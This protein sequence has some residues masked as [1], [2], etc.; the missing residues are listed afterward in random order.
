MF[1]VNCTY[2]KV[3]INEK[4][5]KICKKD[6]C[7]KIWL[8][9]THEKKHS[10]LQKTFFFA[11]IFSFFVRP[12]L[13]LASLPS[14]PHAAPKP[15]IW[16]LVHTSENNTLY[17]WFANFGCVHTGCT[18]LHNA[19]NVLLR[20]NFYISEHSVYTYTEMSNFCMHL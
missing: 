16:R 11:S 19:H 5:V 10:F 20:T 14:T 18:G 8:R 12:Y 17:L 1:H 7:K 6:S 15:I 2:N 13:S 4:N 9:S 3:K